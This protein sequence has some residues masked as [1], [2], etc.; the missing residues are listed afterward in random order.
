M[1]NM[2]CCFHL[3]ISLSL[4]S[5]ALKIMMF[6]SLI[7]CKLFSLF[8][9]FSISIIICTRG[10]YVFCF[11]WESPWSLVTIL[12][13]SIVVWHFSRSHVDLVRSF[14]FSYVFIRPSSMSI[15]Y[16]SLEIRISKTFILDFHL[17][18]SF[19]VFLIFI[20]VRMSP[21]HGWLQVHLRSSRWV[22]KYWAVVS[23][24]HFAQQ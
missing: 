22:V 8:C 4:L 15:F 7:V 16:S 24:M 23:F 21:L 1:K 10:S 2:S 12:L 13:L 19:R 20:I 6:F 14:R 11:L 9:S 3:F 17:V 5:S 18:F